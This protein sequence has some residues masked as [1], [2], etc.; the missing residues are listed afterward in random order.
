MA[1]FVGNIQK[2]QFR[3]RKKL[4]ACLGQNMVME[5]YSFQGLWDFGDDGNV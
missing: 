4:S 1:Q 3:D 5:I 2:R